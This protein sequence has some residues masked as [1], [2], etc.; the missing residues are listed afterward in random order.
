MYFSAAA[1]VPQALALAGVECATTQR[2]LCTVLWASGDDRMTAG[3]DDGV[4][5]AAALRALVGDT[6]V[7]VTLA[8]AQAM[9]QSLA[10][11][12]AATASLLRQPSFDETVERFY[13]LLET[14]AA[15]G[16][17]R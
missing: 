11:V 16:S 4:D 3:A 12:H 8:E 2:K 17:L 6:G 15:E 1:I 14:D 10:R 7:S 13:R 5:R 9:V